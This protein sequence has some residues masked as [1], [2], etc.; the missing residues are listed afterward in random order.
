MV[1]K[2]GKIG[3]IGGMDIPVIH[4]FLAGY[5]AGVEYVDPECEVLTSY[6]GSRLDPETAKSLA[7]AQYDE[8]ADIVFSAAIVTRRDVGFERHIDNKEAK[9]RKKLSNLLSKNL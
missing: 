5:E 9:Q 2:T 6:V 7:F 3:F 1:T 8:G 4:R